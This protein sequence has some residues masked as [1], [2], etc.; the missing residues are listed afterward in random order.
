M[1]Q[2]L[3]VY[4]YS[5]VST[6]GFNKGM[7][8]GACDIRYFRILGTLSITVTFLV[9]KLENSGGVRSGRVPYVTCAATVTAVILS[10]QKR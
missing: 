5:P 3:I 7:L 2:G 6:R 10:M 4:N 9:G 1:M 8:A